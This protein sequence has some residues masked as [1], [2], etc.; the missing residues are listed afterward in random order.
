MALRTRHLVPAAAVCLTSMGAVAG[1]TTTC[2]TVGYSSHLEVR[3]GDDWP[4]RE[5][6]ALDVWC[7]A[8]DP[9]CTIFAGGPPVDQAETPSSAPFTP[10]ETVDPADLG[11]AGA[12]EPADEPSRTPDP[13]WPAPTDPADSWELG[14]ESPAEVLRARVW[15]V[16]TGEIVAEPT[17]SPDWTTDSQGGCPGPTSAT[18][19][20]DPA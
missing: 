20:I 15:D 10:L 18:V 16:R 17:V 7:D 4:D 13:P 9:S 12:D 3:L 2:T 14:L 5:H 11:G 6:L 8:S 19:V 1:C